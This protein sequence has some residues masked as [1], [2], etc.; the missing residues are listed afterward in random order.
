[1]AGYDTYSTV[2]SK[3]YP[4]EEMKTIFS[5]RNRI[6]TWR[7]LWYNLA[8]AE[9]ELG[10]KAITDSALEALKANIKITDKAFDV[11][12]EEERIRRHDVMAHVHA[13]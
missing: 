9:K 13:Y 4:S 2:L 3:R 8:A 12:K 6:S 7:T 5:E 10:I 11:A 1:M